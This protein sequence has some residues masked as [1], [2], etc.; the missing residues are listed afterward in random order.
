[1]TFSDDNESEK[2]ENRRKNDY[3]WWQATN[4]QSPYQADDETCETNDNDISC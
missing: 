1:M 2:N 4:T 3:D